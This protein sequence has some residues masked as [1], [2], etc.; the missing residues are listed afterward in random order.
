[1]AVL[2]LDNLSKWYGEV[3]G[4]NR[5][6]AVIGKGMTGLLGPNGAGKSTLM[7]LA[8]GQ[9]RPSQ[10][11]IRVLGAG[12]WDNPKMLSRVGF[13]P[14]G[15][16]FWG[17][18]TGLDF[19]TFLAKL[20][21][22]RGGDARRAA[23]S[24]IEAVDL[25]AHMRRPIRG[26]SKGMRQRIKVAQALAHKPELLILDE[27][28]TGA[29]PVARHALGTLFKQ[30]VAEGVDIL[31]SSHVLHEVE[32]LT[33]QILLIDH[34]RIVAQGELHEVRRQLHNRPHAIRVRVDGARRVATTVAGL[35]DVTGVRL[36]DAETLLIE[37]SA[38]ERVYVELSDLFLREDL[39]PREIAA[40]DESLEAVFG[41]LTRRQE[42][43]L[44]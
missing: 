42:G 23:L 11:S 16:R 20:S 6:S 37:T 32:A 29:D 9:L 15:D 38:P 31:I 22:L 39:H 27:P 2:E 24:A 7:G 36:A 18:M 26:Y 25:T 19:V 30:L 33:R 8:T 14:E 28:F 4:L 13:C 44:R 1:M 3:I 10:G 34:G 40:A 5:V 17:R 12:P 41:Y 35:D 43:E 21:G